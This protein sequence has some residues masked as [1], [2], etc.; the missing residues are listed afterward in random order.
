MGACLFQSSL[1]KVN[2]GQLKQ[3]QARQRNWVAQLSESDN[4]PEYAKEQKLRT[5][6]FPGEVKQDLYTFILSDKLFRP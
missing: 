4:K 5:E 3:L 6:K 1:I 2:F